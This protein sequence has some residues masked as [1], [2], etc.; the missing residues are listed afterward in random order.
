MAKI[1]KKEEFKPVETST[2]EIKTKQK[3][4]KEKE[5]KHRSAF[6]HRKDR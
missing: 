6:S 3:K 2:A 4:K 5:K 1:E